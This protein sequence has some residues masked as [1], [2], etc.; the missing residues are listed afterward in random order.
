MAISLVLRNIGPT[1]A[2]SVGATSSAA[3]TVS[4]TSN[5][6]GAF[7]SF[8][9]TGSTVVAVT[10]SSTTAN[11]SVLPVAGTPQTVI[12]LPANMI[13]PVVYAVPANASMTAIGSAAGPSLVYITPVAA[14]S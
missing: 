8:L 6:Q 2:I 11:A 13:M 12:M 7:A 4:A 9:N 1:Q 3:I 5:D 14:Q 10:V